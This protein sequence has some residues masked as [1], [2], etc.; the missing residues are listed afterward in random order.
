MAPTEVDYSRYVIGMRQ[1]GVDMVVLTNDISGEVKFVNTAQQ[2]GY[3][4]HVITTRAVFYDPAFADL[5]TG[6]PTNVYSELGSALYFN[7]D[8]RRIPGVALYQVWMK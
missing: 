7:A 6:K 3:A 4:P 1:A 8:E 2:Q 5:V